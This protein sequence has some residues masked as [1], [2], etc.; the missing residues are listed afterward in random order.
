MAARVY[1]AGANTGRGYEHFLE[2]LRPRGE[3]ARICVVRGADGAGRD[4]LLRALAQDWQ[5]QGRTVEC[6]L[7]AVDSRRLQAVTSGD[8]AALDGAEAEPGDWTADLNDA[9]SLQVLPAL[10]GQ[11]AA[12]HRRIRGLSQRAWRCLQVAHTAWSDTAAIYAEA[13]DRGA[14]MNLRME[15]SRWLDGNP[16][17]HRRAYIRA[18]TPEGMVGFPDTLKRPHMLCLDLPWGMDPDALLYPAAVGLRVRGVGYTAAMQ[19]LD[20]DRLAHLCTDTHAVVCWREEGQPC[21]TL[22]FDQA[23]LRREHDALAFNRA[24]FDLWLRQG[25]DTLRGARDCRDQLERLLR[26]VI[27]PEREQEIIG[28]AVAYFRDANG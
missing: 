26:D 9:L 17:P 23:L 27:D 10:R 5:G 20:G 6:W 11:A 21:R 1:F 13:V 7:N 14:V 24:A 28:C 4:A 22:T 15:I 3:A 25:M 2:E 19:P 16:G 8:W 18:A 12:L